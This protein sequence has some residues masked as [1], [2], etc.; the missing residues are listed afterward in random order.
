MFDLDFILKALSILVPVLLV[1]IIITQGVK[2]PPDHAYIISGLRK[3]HQGPDWPGGHQDS[4]FEQMDK[5]YLGQITVDI[6]TM[7]TSPPTTSSMS[8]WMWLPRSGL[9]PMSGG[10]KLAAGTSLTRNRQ[11]SRLTFRIPSRA[12]CVRLSGTHY[13]VL[14]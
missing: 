1:I 5:L 9:P 12:I 11:K 3:Q 14:H 6:K 8:W 13:A 4:I 7:S 2:A 10:W